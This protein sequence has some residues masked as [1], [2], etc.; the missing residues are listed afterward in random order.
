MVVLARF[1]ARLDRDEPDGGRLVQCVGGD[2]APRLLDDHGTRSGRTNSAIS[3]A[4]CAESHPLLPCL[5]PARSRACSS[6][7]V[8]SKP[9]ITG[10][11]VSRPTRMIPRADSPATMSKCAVSPRITAPRQTTAE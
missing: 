6:V 9:S 3:T 4:A 7:S 10:T 11:P 5:P 1:L 8:V 2:L